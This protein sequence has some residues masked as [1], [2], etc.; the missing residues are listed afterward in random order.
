MDWR[1]LVKERIAI[2]GIPLDIFGV[3]MILGN[4]IFLVLEFLKT[5]LLCIVGK[6]AAGGSVT[7]PV[8]VSDM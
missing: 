2:I 5:G 7:V 8:G 3:L 4:K 1:L 6:L